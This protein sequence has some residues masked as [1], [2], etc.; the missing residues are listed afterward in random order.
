MAVY[1][2]GC[3]CGECGFIPYCAINEAVE[4]ELGDERAI[5]FVTGTDGMSVQVFDGWHDEAEPILAEIRT[6][7]PN[8]TAD[9]RIYRRITGVRPLTKVHN[10]IHL[11]TPSKGNDKS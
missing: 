7:F 8:V 1:G 10:L 5:V 11:A 3:F 2:E 4:A 6:E 9:M